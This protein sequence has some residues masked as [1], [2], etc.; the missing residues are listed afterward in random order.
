MLERGIQGFYDLQVH[1][2]YCIYFSTYILLVYLF[3]HTRITIQD[4]T[5]V[6]F[7]LLPEIRCPIPQGSG[8]NQAVAC[9]VHIGYIL[10]STR[11]Q[12]YMK[13]ER[14]SLMKKHDDTFKLVERR[15]VLDDR[16]AQRFAQRHAARNNEPQVIAPPVLIPSATLAQFNNHA[17]QSHRRYVE[18]DTSED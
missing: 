17:I 1:G 12:E 14:V 11:P 18:M 16:N 8:F 5:S 4:A 13:Y 15:D 10:M 6:V 9:V 3:N 2:G 7:R